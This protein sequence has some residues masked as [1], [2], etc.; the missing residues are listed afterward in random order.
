VKWI[1]NNVSTFRDLSWI[2]VTILEYPVS[3]P[4]SHKSETCRSITVPTKDRRY[5]KLLG[6]AEPYRRC[7]RRNVGRAELTSQ[8]ETDPNGLDI[9]RQLTYHQTLYTFSYRKRRY[10][11]DQPT[12]RYKS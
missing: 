1:Q 3:G 4:L 6:R 9:A 12:D 8:L 2:F 5:K 10:M 7:G 11:K